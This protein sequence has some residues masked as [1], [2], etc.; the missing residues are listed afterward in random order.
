MTAGSNRPSLRAIESLRDTEFGWVGEHT[1]IILK[2]TNVMTQGQPNPRKNS[3]NGPKRY[4]NRFFCGFDWLWGMTSVGFKTII[5][6][7]TTFG[8]SQNTLTALF[9]N[10]RYQVH[11]TWFFYR[12]L[13]QLDDAF[14]SAP[15]APFPGPS[16]SRI[17]RRARWLRLKLEFP[18]DDVEAWRLMLEGT[19]DSPAGTL[20]APLYRFCRQLHRRTLWSDASGDAMGG[21]VVW[22][23]KAI[24]SSYTN[25]ISCFSVEG[26]APATWS[27]ISFLLRQRKKTTTVL[28]EAQSQR[29][30]SDLYSIVKNVG[31]IL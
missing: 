28:S 31:G 10:T 7:A 15:A 29:R 19:L 3:K 21:E 30:A 13:S 5:T 17:T 18:A 8:I 24:F 22:R 12:P 9:H 6:C 11:G 1:R 23:T 25:H 2:P 20:H 27:C 4:F 14:P 26:Y 16:C